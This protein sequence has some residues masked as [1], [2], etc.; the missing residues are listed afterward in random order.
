MVADSVSAVLEGSAEEL[1]AWKKTLLESCVKWLIRSYSG[2]QQDGTQDQEKQILL[3]LN[4]LLVGVFY[5]FFFRVL[6]TL[7]RE[8]E[9]YTNQGLQI[10]SK[11]GGMNVAWWEM[12]E[13]RSRRQR[14]RWGNL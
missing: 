5:L 8:R 9:R 14:V 4:E 7:L 2:T 3:R 12:R 10:H 1:R 6:V 11:S 13:A